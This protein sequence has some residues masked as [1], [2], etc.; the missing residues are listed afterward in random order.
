MRC[1]KLQSLSSKASSYSI[2]HLLSVLNLSSLLENK[3]V[4]IVYTIYIPSL[5]IKV[6]CFIFTF[7]LF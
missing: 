7:C 6:F 4:E 5:E 3:N 2:I 1:V